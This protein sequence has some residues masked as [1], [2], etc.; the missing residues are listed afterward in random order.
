MWGWIVTK[1]TIENQETKLKTLIK[2]L[3]IE[4]KNL[5]LNDANADYENVKLFSKDVLTKKNYSLKVKDAE[6]VGKVFQQL[7]K[8]EITDA[9]VSRLNHSKLDSLKK[10]VKIMAIKAAKNKATYLL[11][12]IDE[13][14]GKALIVEERENNLAQF[15]NSKV[16][17]NSMLSNFRIGRGDKQEDINNEIQFKKIKIE[18]FIFVK[19]GIK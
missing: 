8:L 2:D 13:Q 12:A 1:I 11:N 7:E 19:F 3:G 18:A 4:V 6:T 9:F 5:T 17:G 10:E 16:R 15:G 14:I